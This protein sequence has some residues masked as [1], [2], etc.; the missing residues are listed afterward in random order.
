MCDKEQKEGIS[1]FLFVPNLNYQLKQVS[2]Y[3]ITLSLNLTWTDYHKIL[4]KWKEK[5]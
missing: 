5:R 2:H 4:H 1:F 3:E